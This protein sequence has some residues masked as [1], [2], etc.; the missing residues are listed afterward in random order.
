L[1]FFL[2][3]TLAFAIALALGLGSAYGALWFEAKS[4]GAGLT[5]E[6]P[7]ARAAF[8]VR[9]ILPKEPQP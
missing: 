1:E 5:S 6:N 3:F 8:A 7:Y 4:G 2:K 9:D